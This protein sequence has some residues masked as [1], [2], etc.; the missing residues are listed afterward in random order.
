MRLIGKLVNTILVKTVTY[1]SLSD[2]T[3]IR[4]SSRGKMGTG[5]SLLLECENGGLLHCERHEQFKK[6]QCDFSS[7]EDLDNYLT[8]FCT[9]KPQISLTFGN[10]EIQSCISKHKYSNA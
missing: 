9:N 3:V 7:L 8:Q 6:W 5:I 10:G 2:V 4:G 1:Y